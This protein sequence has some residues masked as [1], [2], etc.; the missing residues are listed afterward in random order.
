MFDDPIPA[1]LYVV[2]KAFAQAFGH[3]WAAPGADAS[4]EYLSVLEGIGGARKEPY[5]MRELIDLEM[6]LS[7]LRAEGEEKGGFS[8][9]RRD[10][11]LPL[12]IWVSAVEWAFT[13]TNGEN[14]DWI[15]HVDPR[16]P[17]RVYIRAEICNSE[18]LTLLT[19]YAKYKDGNPPWVGDLYVDREMDRRY[20]DAVTIQH[21][22]HG[23]YPEHIE[24]AEQVLNVFRTLDPSFTIGASS[25]ATLTPDSELGDM[26]ELRR[27]A[28]ERIK[29]LT[30]VTWSDPPVTTNDQ[31]SIILP[32]PDSQGTSDE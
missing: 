24:L 30:I 11:K 22:A 23:V 8:E 4:P 18:I 29:E 28:D 2:A 10:Y 20:T 31:M 15:L 17:E 9:K 27:L 1:S 19:I 7:R 21:L 13:G 3:G 12:P 16:E 32:E 5:T 6:E 26:L 25:A 14:I